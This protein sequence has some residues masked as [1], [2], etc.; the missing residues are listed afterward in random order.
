MVTGAMARAQDA[1]A[2]EYQQFAQ[3][4][5][6]ESHTAGFHFDRSAP[7]RAKKLLALKLTDPTLRAASEEFVKIAAMYDIAVFLRNKSSWTVAD[8]NKLK[9][10]LKFD[11]EDDY[12][13]YLGRGL[14]ATLAKV[15]LLEIAET[16]AL[17][18]RTRH[19]RMWTDVMAKVEPTGGAEQDAFPV[20]IGALWVRNVSGQA[21]T[22]VTIAINTKSSRILPA[23][24]SLHVVFFDRLEPDEWHSLP[25]L[26]L[27][28]LA[29]AK[30]GDYKPA[31]DCF[32]C[33]VW[34]DQARFADV[35]F[36]LKAIPPVKK[37]PLAGGKPY[38]FG[39]FPG[40]AFTG[41]Y[42]DTT[43]WTVPPR[44]AQQVAVVDG[45]WIGQDG[46]TNKPFVLKIIDIQGSRFYAAGGTRE[47]GAPAVFEGTICDGKIE[48]EP[49]VARLGDPDGPSYRGTIKG[50]TMELSYG[51]NRAKDG[52][53]SLT[54]KKHKPTIVSIDA[55]TEADARN[56]ATKRNPG[57]R[58]VSLE[59]QPDY[60]PYGKR[61]HITMEPN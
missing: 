29:D 5:S 59:L 16:I 32:R 45:T 49:V 8:Y 25:G 61:W 48:W 60:T 6:M 18:A 20:R 43:P 10:N 47:A 26:L 24:A 50:D 23:D 34:T 42:D 31:K 11:N 3:L 1:K 41:K 19:S 28:K 57:F 17:N 46:S 37:A 33:S 39:C 13:V 2:R 14:G 38:R 15:K 7:W 36:D 27:N 53:I 56:L 9:E 22:N 40:A 44:S 4:A 21:Q 30:T 35:P 58:I 52:T 55:K 54:F 12:D 51:K